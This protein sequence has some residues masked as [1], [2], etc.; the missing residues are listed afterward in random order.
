MSNKCIWKQQDDDWGTWETECGNAFV[1]N[2]DGAP[3]E[4]DMN[5]CCYCGHKLLEELLEVLDA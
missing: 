2:D 5:Y 4:Y 1:L 3:I